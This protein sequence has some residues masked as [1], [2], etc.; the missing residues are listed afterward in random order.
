MQPYHC[1]D[2][3][4]EN[5]KNEEEHLKHGGTIP[6]KGLYNHIRYGIIVGITGGSYG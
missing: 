1:S 4:D 5:C 6:H 3:S 2:V